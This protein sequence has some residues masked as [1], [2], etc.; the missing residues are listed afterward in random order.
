MADVTLAAAA[1]WS[2]VNAGGPPAVGD[3]VLLGTTAAVGY[4]LT[5]DNSITE[6][7]YSVTPLNITS[8]LPNGSFSWDAGASTGTVISYAVTVA[9]T[10]V[11]GTQPRV[12][13][14]F[15]W[16]GGSGVVTNWIPTTSVMHF[17]PTGTVPGAGVTLTGDTWAATTSAA[18]V[19]TLVYHVV[20]GGT[21]GASDTLVGTGWGGSSGGSAA[22]TYAF[23]CSSII[24]SNG[25]TPNNGTIVLSNATTTING[26]LTAGIVTLLATAAG[27]TLAVNG[28]ATAGTVGN[29]YCIDHVNGTAVIAAA[30]GGL[31]STTYG[32]FQENGGLVIGRVTGS[33]GGRSHGLYVAYCTYTAI[34][35]AKGGSNETSIGVTGFG[36][37]FVV[38]GTD[39]TGAG[40]PVGTMGSLVRIAPGVKLQFHN[41]SGVPTEYY[42]GTLLPDPANVRLGTPYGGGEFVGTLPTGVP[43]SRVRSG[44]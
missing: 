33:S 31:G 29:A 6:A 20:S 28:V 35:I 26:D 41:T 21:I 7:N 44:M 19:V 9:L 16:S 43:M 5:L 15:T 25:T 27:K 34:G 11:T 14:T 39:L 38:N 42:D 36:G 13:E 23:V 4:P 32:V 2:T 12:G 8:G 1:N 18:S 30:G 22:S 40:P 3:R 37:T 10:M 17:T 24:A